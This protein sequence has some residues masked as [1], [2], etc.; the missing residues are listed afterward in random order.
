[1]SFA[2]PWSSFLRRR[3]AR[4]GNSTAGFRPRSCAGAPKRA[5]SKGSRPEDCAMSSWSQA[6]AQ[7][8]SP[9]AAPD[10]LP[11]PLPWRCTE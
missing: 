2:R 7:R 9:G 5:R 1:M 4:F 3:T 10:A 6:E 8:E 11:G